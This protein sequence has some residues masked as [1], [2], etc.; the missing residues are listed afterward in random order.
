MAI[1]EIKINPK[2]NGGKGIERMYAY[3]QETKQNV[4]RGETRLHCSCLHQRGRAPSLKRTGRT[5]K[6]GD[7]IFICKRCGKELNLEKLNTDQLR[8]AVSIVDRAIDIIK[9]LA[10]PDNEKDDKVLK[11][12]VKTQ[13]RLLEIPRH[14]DAAIKKSSGENGQ[15]NK[16][17]NAGGSST[18]IGKS[19][20]GR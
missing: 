19:S 12:L 15:K 18:T 10:N 3:L 17:R 4:A 2:E 14:Y 8:D 1:E 7:P 5:D 16:N 11:R 20:V 9:I 13:F 6:N